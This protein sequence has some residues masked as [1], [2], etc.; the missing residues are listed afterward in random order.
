MDVSLRRL[1]TADINQV[2]EI[3]KEA[4]TPV[5]VTTPFK[6]ELDNR[7]AR[8]LVAYCRETEG[9]AHN[10]GYPQ[11]DHSLWSRIAVKIGL[12][13]S[14]QPLKTQSQDSSI[15]GYVGIWFQ[16]DEAHI[17]EIAVRQQ[18]RGHGI[19]E[20]LLIGSVRAAIERG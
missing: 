8:Y 12:A 9:S 1:R 20:L 14:E 6:R 10:S 3:E 4:F 16:G 13:R 17:T 7:F 19:G 15:A 2:V 11:Q 5:W 18:L